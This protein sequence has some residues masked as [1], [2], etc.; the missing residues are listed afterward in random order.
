MVTYE[1]YLQYEE[2]VEGCSPK[3]KE[4]KSSVAITGIVKV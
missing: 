4:I 3:K 1:N 2:S